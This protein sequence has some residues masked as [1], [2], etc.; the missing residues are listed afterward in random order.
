METE[1]TDLRYATVESEGNELHYPVRFTEKGMGGA[2]HG[3]NTESWRVDEATLKIN[4]PIPRSRFVLE[5]WPDEEVYD[6]NKD[7]VIPAKD[8]SWS[9]VGK[10]GFPWDGFVG[11]LEVHEGKR[12]RERV[13]AA[14][15]PAPEAARPWAEAM[16]GWIVLAGLAVVGGGGYVVYRQRHARQPQRRVG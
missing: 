9:A 1:I 16:G 8:P 7:K 2:G 6:L 12:E 11:I 13:A 10:V 3:G 5:P 4:M 14:G 15:S